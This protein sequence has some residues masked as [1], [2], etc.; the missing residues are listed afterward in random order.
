MKSLNHFGTIRRLFL[1]AMALALV[2]GLAAPA[3]AAQ[4]QAPYQSMTTSHE[5]AQFT[6]ELFL[7]DQYGMPIAN[8]RTLSA[9]DTIYVEIRLA[10]EGYKSPSY[11]S[12]GIEFRLLT[13]GLTYNY[14]GSSLRSGTDI[15]ELVYADGNS[16]GFAWYDMQ[17]KGE[18]VNNPVLAGS[19]SY[20]V[21]D[22]SMVNITIPVAL[23]YITGEDDGYIAE[24]PATLYLDPNGGKIIGEDVSG[25]YTSGD[26][27][28]LPD[29]E[30]GDAVFL[31][32]SDG[33]RL[34]P[35][36]SRYTVSGI[37]TLTAQWGE[38][39]RNRYLTL[40]PNGGELVGEDIS[41][42]Y[43]DGE[44]VVLPGV[45]REGYRFLSWNDG[46]ADYGEN[47]EYTVYNTVTITAQWEPLPT[48]SDGTDDPTSPEY[49][50]D[51]GFGGLLTGGAGLLFLLLLLLLLLW[52]RRYVKYSLVNGDVALNYKNG[53][54]DV[55]VVVVLYDGDREL[56][57]AKSSTVKAK[58]RLRY[59][60]N[61]MRMPIAAIETGKYDGKLI[62]MDGTNE[63]VKK[64]RIKVLDRELKKS[65]K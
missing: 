54:S 41:G 18:S 29:A 32:W 45:V 47:E 62:I 26:V 5:D 13:R 17:Q 23:I 7:T 25:T 40:D 36:G 8:P 19:W 46:L 15:R 28:I 43:A 9:G 22:P 31:G 12:Y 30:L 49:P 20:T 4:T 14:D 58:R 59:I 2:T 35:A 34:Y 11:D 55:H 61:R 21:E 65:K 52:K 64:C 33:V 27:V 57:L 60:T 39:N 24:G 63:T 3:L 50:E 6:Y 42:Y 56:Y 38:L 44:I 53:E 16:V 37:V 48:E 10:R 51:D 1:L